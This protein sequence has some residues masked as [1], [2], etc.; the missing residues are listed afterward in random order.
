METARHW[1]LSHAE[2]E[3]D[4]QRPVTDW[5]L[6]ARGRLRLEALAACG[7]VPAVTRIASSAERKAVETAG[8]LARALSLPVT[9]RADMGEN[10]RTSTGYLPP[11]EFEA[12]A[13]AFFASPEASVGGWESAAA[14]QGRIVNAVAQILRGT[15]GPV[16]FV[17]H[18][19]VGTLLWCHLAGVAID[20]RH[21]QPAGGGCVFGFG[22]G[23]APDRGWR[24]IEDW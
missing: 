14:A 4:P 18:G 2:V 1:Y 5:G 15:S 7:R 10:D 6:S 21:D 13:D 24:R 19:A 12:M 11:A 3:I 17:G 16:L 20:R 23:A 8:I 9:V 22:G